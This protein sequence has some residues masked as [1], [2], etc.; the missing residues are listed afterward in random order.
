V[1][2]GRLIFSRACLPDTAVL[3][4]AAGA[5]SIIYDYILYHKKYNVNIKNDIFYKNLD[6]FW[7]TT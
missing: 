6:I 3:S 1:A 2:G 5:F 4:R 7:E